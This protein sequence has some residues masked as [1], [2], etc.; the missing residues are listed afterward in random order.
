MIDLKRIFLNNTNNTFLQLFRY[1][2]V[3]GMAFIADFGL[4][5]VLT[6]YAHFHYLLSATFAFIVGVVLNY[7]LSKKWVFSSNTTIKKQWIEFA[8]FSLIGIVGLALN[9]LFLWMFTDYCSIHYMFSK[10]LTTVIVFFWNFLARKFVL[11]NATAG[12]LP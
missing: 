10:A 1:A 2:F 6:E 12:K 7:L 8:V 9:N 5:Y 11:F 4:L 3:G